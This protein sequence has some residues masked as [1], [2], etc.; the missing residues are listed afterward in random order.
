M[1]IFDASIFDPI[2]F[3]SAAVGSGNL[4]S[5]SSAVGC[6]A[7]SGSVASPVALVAN[8]AGGTG[9]WT[10]ALSEG[11]FGWY[12]ASDASTLNFGGSNLTQWRDK[13]PSGRHLAPVATGPLLTSINGLGALSFTD[14]GLRSDVTAS[15]ADF[16]ACAVFR[17]GSASVVYERLLDHGFTTGWWLGRKGSTSTWG[18]GVMETDPPYGRF[19][20]LAN[21]LV[22]QIAMRRSGTTHTVSSGG[23]SEIGSVSGAVTTEK[24]VFVGD[25]EVGGA[26][27][28][29]AICEIATW[30]LLLSASDLAKVE[31]YL[32]W[33]WGIQAAL[34]AGH[35]Y[36]N[37]APLAGGFATLI[38]AGTVQSRSVS[39]NLQ[40]QP[41]AMTG[42][43]VPVWI[44]GGILVSGPSA[45]G[46]ISVLTA[47]GTLQPSTAT[48]VGTGVS[49]SVSSSAVLAASNTSTVGTGASIS[50]GTGVLSASS[51]A[52]TAD[53]FVGMTG[54]GALQVTGAPAPW[55][56]ELVA[57]LEGW[58]DAT[59]LALSDGAG[60]PV[61]TNVGA[62]AV[63]AMVGTP[64]PVFRTGLLNGLPVVRFSASEGRL[65]NTF[66]KQYDHTVV[67]IARRWG[68]TGGRC[69]TAPYPEGGNHLIGYHSS[70]YDCCHDDGGWI[71]PPTTYPATGTDPWRMYGADGA[72]GQGVRFFRNGELL[73]AN[74]VAPGNF[75]FRYNISGYGLTGAEETGDF[76]VAEVL[77]YDSKLSDA[78]REKVEGYLA[79]KWG[80]AAELP[81]GHPY[82]S[83]PP[84]GA[85]SGGVSLDGAGTVLTV[86]G[87]A[88]RV[89]FCD[90]CLDRHRPAGRQRR[91]HIGC[92]HGHRLCP[93]DGGWHGSAAGKFCFHQRL[94]GRHSRRWHRRAAG[95][96]GADRQRWAQQIAGHWHAHRSCVGY[97]E[98]RQIVVGRHERAACDHLDARRERQGGSAA[99]CRHWHADRR[100]CGGLRRG[101]ACGDHRLQDRSGR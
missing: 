90:D 16:T 78:D 97:R 25:D 67:Y 38:G 71:V 6:I 56:P 65:R 81:V 32:A 19:V 80:M 59:K 8:Y 93:D 54:T 41:H 91:S 18:G 14:H 27:L 87:G 60:V 36:K 39:A 28:I 99:I 69:F 21:N 3:D 15:F 66:S 42:V 44:G 89:W 2:V 52:L 75:G 29:G 26:P 76:D 57:G 79:H 73:A 77:V 24:R 9:P 1:P 94:R 58:H 30:P 48:L 5:V 13:S 84:V 20:T 68:A 35:A 82:K 98:P 4:V 88:L 22:H 70:G 40:A 55:T 53:V 92:D 74:P 17:A 49:R 95:A 47:V 96:V 46:A 34:P 43:I 86:I 101:R 10:P 7:V 83:A 23:V 85:P 12:D 62:G 11:M 64:L 63:P 37:A 51:S 100:A 45:V 33:K 72:S 50:T 31:G 61:W